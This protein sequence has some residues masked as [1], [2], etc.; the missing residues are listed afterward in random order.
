VE[1]S[2][3]EPR[4]FPLK[5]KSHR[6][7][8]PKNRPNNRRELCRHIHDIRRRWRS[9]YRLHEAGIVFHCASISQFKF[10]CIISTHHA[11]TCFDNECSSI[12]NLAYLVCPARPGG[13]SGAPGHVTAMEKQLGRAV[14]TARRT[15]G[16]R[17]RVIRT[18]LSP[19][20]ALRLVARHR[21]MCSCAELCTLLLPLQSCQVRCHCELKAGN[22]PRRAQH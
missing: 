18:T 16:R 3:A 15:A 6:L 7:T 17:T 21:G 2:L 5:K 20:R 1:A 14:A 22:Q 8:P 13:A 4:C 19:I 12:W 11:K 9:S 10:E